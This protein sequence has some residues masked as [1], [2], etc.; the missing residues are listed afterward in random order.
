MS[1]LLLEQQTEV[2]QSGCMVGPATG[3]PCESEL[4][5]YVIPGPPF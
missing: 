1:E 4:T 2:L 5:A 3:T